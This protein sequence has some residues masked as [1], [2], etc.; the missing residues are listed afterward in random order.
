MPKILLTVSHHKQRRQADCLAACAAM[1]IDYLGKRVDYDRLNRLLGIQDYGAP[2]SNVAQLVHLGVRVQHSQGNLEDIER[3]LREGNPA[4][5]FLRTGELP[6]WDEDTGHAVVVVGMDETSVYINDPAFTLAPQT[7][8]HGDFML[9]WLE[10]DY[11]YV[12]V[13]V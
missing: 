12:I 13:R 2:I 1:L 9:A 3:L 6:Y 10:F 4:I 7:V 5:V 11:A 8:S